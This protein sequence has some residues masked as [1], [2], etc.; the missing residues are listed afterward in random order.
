MK[1]FYHI[2]ILLAFALLLNE[3]NAQ[4]RLLATNVQPTASIEL[5]QNF[6][7]PSRAATQIPLEISKTTFIKI[8]VYNLIG[9][10]VITLI[11]KE[12]PA[13][14]HEI[15]FDTSQLKSGVYLYRLTSGDQRF[16]RRMTVSK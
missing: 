6:P 7:N 2:I 10:K 9:A 11:N 4:S 12:L 15:K 16:T 8:E 5:G 1:R 14:R 3:A 13:G